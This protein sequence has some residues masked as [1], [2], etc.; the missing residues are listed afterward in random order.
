M[1]SLCA[2]GGG[3]RSS[4]RLCAQPNSYATQLEREMMIAKR[5]DDMPMIGMC[6]L[7]LW[8]HFPMVRLLR[9]PFRWGFRWEILIQSVLHLLS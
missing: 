6:N 2:R 9:T 1:R 8:F 3:G 5:R 7:H 4:R